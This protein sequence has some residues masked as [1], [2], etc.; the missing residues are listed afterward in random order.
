MPGIY[1]LMSSGQVKVGKRGE[2]MFLIGRSMP[3]L[4]NK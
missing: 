1:Q 2:I 3:F 4:L